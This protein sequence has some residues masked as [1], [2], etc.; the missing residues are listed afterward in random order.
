MR[1]DCKNTYGC[2]TN[3]K[4]ESNTFDVLIRNLNPKN[5]QTMIKMSCTLT[6]GKCVS[7]DG[8]FRLENFTIE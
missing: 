7:K 5:H 8:K 3:V 2:R 6:D 4:I 1:A